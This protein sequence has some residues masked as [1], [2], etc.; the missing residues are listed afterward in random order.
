MTRNDEVIHVVAAIIVSG[1]HVLACRRAKHKVS[2][3]L[4]EFPGGKI[5]PG[6][7]SEQALR[8]E[9]SEELT[10]ALGTVRRFDMSDTSLLDNVIRLETF[11]CFPTEEFSGGSTDHDAF[12]WL[13]KS[14]LENVLWAP[15]DIP[16]VKKLLVSDFDLLT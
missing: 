13:S 8:R 16:A 9:L 12:I 6:E 2:A 15:P 1:N 7:D 11:L 4:W 3:G 14:E 10:L 5:E